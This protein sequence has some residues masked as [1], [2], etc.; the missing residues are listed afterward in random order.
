MR[1]HEVLALAVARRPG[2]DRLAGGLTL[3]AVKPG[4]TI[5]P[6][7]RRNCGSPSI[8]AASSWLRV[9]FHRMQ[10][11]NTSSAASSSVAPLANSAPASNARPFSFGLGHL[12]AINGTKAERKCTHAFSLIQRNGGAISHEFMDNL[13]GRLA[14][15][16]PIN[17]SLLLKDIP[18]LTVFITL[19]ALSVQLVTIFF[20]HG[21]LQ[22]KN[23][24]LPAQ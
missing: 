5:L 14:W 23:P 2:I 3:G 11:R 7:T 20:I 24:T 16:N 15:V 13:T 4:N 8:S 6:V 17:H 18:I 21:F 10:G 19:K 22:T 12:C 9:S 1:S